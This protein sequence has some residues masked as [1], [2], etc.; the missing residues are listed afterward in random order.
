MDPLSMVS[1][2]KE[3]LSEATLENLDL[4]R[5]FEV[6][7]AKG[8]NNHN[9]LREIIYL[10]NK[11]QQAYLWNCPRLVQEKTFIPPNPF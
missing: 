4:F 2:R 6:E 5:N 7:S 1:T 11:W 10:Y 8:D 9:A 3:C